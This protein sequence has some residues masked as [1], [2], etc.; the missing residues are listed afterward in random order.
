MTP[1][2]AHELNM[3]TLFIVVGLPILVVLVGGL[4]LHMAVA[5]AVLALVFSHPVLAIA[6]GA[7]WLFPWRWF[8]DAV[9]VGL[10][11]RVSGFA[12]RLSR[13]PRYPRRRPWT[14]TE[15]DRQDLEWRHGAPRSIGRRPNN[16]NPWPGDEI[17]IG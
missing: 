10:G 15:L 4:I 5:V 2:L 9:A 17:A 16:Y 1:E 13:R 12:S 3:W 14:R 11:L 8:A 6:L 7:V